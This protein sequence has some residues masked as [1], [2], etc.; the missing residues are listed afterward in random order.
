MF[1]EF[2]CSCLS[3]LKDKLVYVLYVV[4]LCRFLF[5]FFG[6]AMISI[7]AFKQGGPLLL[8]PHQ[9]VAMYVMTLHTCSTCTCMLDQR[10]LSIGMSKSTIPSFKDTSLMRTASE[11]PIVYSCVQP[12]SEIRT[13]LQSG[14]LLRSQ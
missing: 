9:R 3:E 4:C 7:T 1:Q 6:V 8:P 11:V 2:F 10:H 12:T 14:Q 13:P 5:C